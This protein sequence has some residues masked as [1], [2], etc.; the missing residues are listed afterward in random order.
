MTRSRVVTKRPIIEVAATSID[1]AC[2]SVGNSIQRHTK[3][4]CIVA[5]AYC[6]VA[7]HH[8]WRIS[9]ASDFSIYYCA[10]AAWDDWYRRF[11]GTGSI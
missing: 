5:R 6:R 2:A 11:G 10:N 9:Y 7:P 4:F 1:N 8:F 3:T